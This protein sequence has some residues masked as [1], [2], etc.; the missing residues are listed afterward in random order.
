M[1]RS[2]GG[3]L[4]AGYGAVLLVSVSVAAAAPPDDVRAALQQMHQW[5]GSGEN[6]RRWKS[7]LKSDQLQAELADP[8][9]ADASALQEVLA[10]YESS[11]A[12][13]DMPRFAAVRRTLRQWIGSLPPPS[14]EDLVE[15]ALQAK[16]AFAPVTDEDLERARSRL[17][18]AVGRLD[19]YLATGGANGQAWQEYLK[20]QILEAQMAASATP[21]LARLVEVYRR[22]TADEE[23]LELPVFADVADAL[24]VYLDLVSF[25][26][27]EDPGQRFHQELDAL[28]ESLQRYGAQPTEPEHRAIGERLGWLDAGGQ[29]ASLV[30]KVRRS[31]SLPNLL[32]RVSKELVQAGFTRNVDRV[33]PVR[34]VIL[35]T[36]IRGT[37]RTTGRLSLNLV[38]DTQ[39]AVLELVLKG[40]SASG[41]RGWNGPVTIHSD[42]QTRIHAIKRI[43]IDQAGLRGVPAASAARTRTSVRGIGTRHG[44]F[45]GNIVRNQASQR[46][47]Q[48]RGRSE[49]IAARHAEDRVN[50][51]MN[52]ESNA[53]LAKGNQRFQEDFRK[54]LL[55]RRAFP[56]LFRFSTT[57][58]SLTLT[59]LQATPYQLGAPDE[60]PVLKQ[61]H[62]LA[63]RVHESMI[64]NLA[65][66]L[67]ADRKFTDEDAQQA[68]IDLLGEIPDKLRKQ[69]DDLP[70]SI[71]FAR[72]EP[73]TMLF[74]DG[75]FQLTLR[76]SAYTSGERSYPAMNITVAYQLKQRDNGATLVRQGDLDI[77]PPGFVEGESTLSAAQVALRRL[78][79]KKLGKVFEPEIVGE[80]IELK[81]DWSNAGRLV[82][83]EMIARQGWLALG[84][85]SVH[86]DGPAAN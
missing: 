51:R 23:G 56:Q 12:G 4:A 71:T 29:A 28:A 57:Q 22:F 55:R 24:R 41:T 82:V 25:T 39:Q 66:A 49:Y 17:A 11:A 65:A 85:D 33:D 38:P 30:R 53:R 34:D 60:P 47:A 19:A 84:Y 3:G 20:L 70:W 61:N 67:I 15:A 75:S 64:N 7:Y 5:V 14:P 36:R 21:S 31:L 9:A 72:R 86:D 78:I 69:E 62:D 58:Q 10:Q 68:A 16:D 42:S 35:G 2:I 83:S 45:I 79:G 27:A 81:D 80:G 48:N 18:A 44:G 74:A 52:I 1:I 32:V 54:P 43:V 13:L 8:A 40:T 6:G 77:L 46:V 26:Q 50:R 59:A 76:G 73:M 37:A 63:V